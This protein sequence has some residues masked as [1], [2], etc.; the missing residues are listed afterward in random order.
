MTGNK[1]LLFYGEL[2]SS[3]IH[4]IAISNMINL[5]LLRKFFHIEIIEEKS[6]LGEIKRITYIKI[7]RLAK[8]QV[9]IL[10]KSI[11]KHFDYFYLSLSVS[12]FGCLKNLCAIICFRLFNRGS[13]ILHIH[14]GDFLDWYFKNFLNRL[15]ARPV[16][17]LSYK[18]IVL[19]EVQ[20]AEFIK[21]FNKTVCV[22]HNTIEVETDNPSFKKLTNRFLFISNYLYEKGILDLLEVFKRVL[23]KYPDISLHTFG[24]FPDENIKKD[25]LRYSNSSIVINDVITGLDKFVEIER[26]DCLILPSLNEGE[27]MVILEAMAS[28]TPVISTKVGLIPEMVGEDYPFLFPPGDQE[29]LED[30]IIHFINFRDLPRISE[31]LK[32]RY[33]LNYSNEIHSEDLHKIFI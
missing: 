1:S 25:I 5:D 3:A 17:K 8:D 20:K 14:R 9:S 12:F 21:H 13:V 18:I 26:A 32:E 33:I 6:T 24:T 4:G 30:K 10:T 19:S 29:S 15:V 28:G 23:T 2:P 22:L 7:L 27:P 11:K 16:I 31:G